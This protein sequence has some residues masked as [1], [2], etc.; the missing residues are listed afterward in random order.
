[1][2]IIKYAFQ[3]LSADAFLKGLSFFEIRSHAMI[4]NARPI[5]KAIATVPALLFFKKRTPT[6]VIMPTI[7]NSRK[8]P[9]VSLLF[10][11]VVI[12]MLP[13]SNTGRVMIQAVRKSNLNP[14]RKASITCEKEYCG[15][16][17]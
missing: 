4:S 17:K 7:I 5:N 10:M 13:N 2:A 3:I 14:N 12:Y 8:L 11:D 15:G 1:M 6:V 9:A 16:W